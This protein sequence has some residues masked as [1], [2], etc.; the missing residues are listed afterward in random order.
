MEEITITTYKYDNKEFSSKEEVDN[1]KR[2]YISD[3]NLI[4][5]YKLFHNIP[6]DEGNYDIA[7]VPSDAHKY[8]IVINRYSDGTHLLRIKELFKTIGDNYITGVPVYNFLN[9]DLTISPNRDFKIGGTTSRDTGG[10]VVYCSKTYS[11]YNIVS[12]F[13]LLKKLNIY[14]PNIS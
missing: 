8:E 2:L 4:E 10:M 9:Q 6:E 1:Y 14:I 12:Y 13:Y 11:T 3:E 7:K 5:I